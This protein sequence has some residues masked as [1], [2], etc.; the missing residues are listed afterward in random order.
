ML[1]EELLKKVFEE[2]Q[3]PTPAEVDELLR[4]YDSKDYPEKYEY[5]L[6]QLARLYDCFTEVVDDLEREIHDFLT[7]NEFYESTTMTE[8]LSYDDPE[9]FF[10]VICKS[11]A[12]DY[13]L[14]PE[15]VQ[16]FFDVYPKTRRVIDDL[17]QAKEKY[18]SAIMKYLRNDPSAPVTREEARDVLNNMMELLRHY[19]VFEEGH[20]ADLDSLTRRARTILES[21]GSPHPDYLHTHLPTDPLT[22]L[23]DVL[24]DVETFVYDM[25]SKDVPALAGEFVEFTNKLEELLK[26][27]PVYLIQNPINL[28]EDTL[29]R[30]QTC[31]WNIREILRRVEDVFNLRIMSEGV[32]INVYREFMNFFKNRLHFDP[33]TDAENI[34]TFKKP[35]FTV[36]EFI[37][38]MLQKGYDYC[39]DKGNYLVFCRNIDS[40]H[41]MKVYI[42]VDNGIVFVSSNGTIPRSYILYETSKEVPN[43]CYCRTNG[44][45]YS[46]R[47]CEERCPEEPMEEFR[48]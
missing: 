39:D 6:S 20:L 38:E 33:F 11:R 26:P 32:D 19:N 17:R 41:W 48:L 1:S 47:E 40:E 31:L 12:Y 16:S 18:E 46:E 44:E 37:D 8:A 2:R 10:H 23:A 29:K 30:V 3:T 14:P 4:I 24:L 21:L 36:Q 35:G 28:D 27:D 45:W 22:T 9:Q 25:Q 15:I 5:P 43:W 13:S 7:S 42:P 34:I